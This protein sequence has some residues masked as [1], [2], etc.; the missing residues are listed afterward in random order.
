MATILLIDDELDNLEMLRMVMES[1]GHTVEMT[2]DG[3]EGKELITSREIDLVLT[4]LRMSP[5]N[6][7]EVLA[8]AREVKPELPVI[9][10]TAYH[11]EEAQSEAD[12]LGCVAYFKKPFILKELLSTI[13]AS[14]GPE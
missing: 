9:I 5:V 8:H 11:S 10:I 1:E 7:M 4:D 3:G 14:L 2:T 12:A 6:G 13:K